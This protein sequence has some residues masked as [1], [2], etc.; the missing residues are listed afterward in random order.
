MPPQDSRSEEPLIPLPF[1]DRQCEEQTNSSRDE[2][3]ENGSGAENEIANLSSMPRNAKLVLAYTWV[4]F[5]G[6][7]LWN[8]N[9]L[10]TLVF[11]L[12]DGDPKAIGFLTAAM[13]MAQ[14]CTSIPTGILADKYRRDTL[15]KVGALVGIAAVASSIRA[16]LQPG[17]RM[18]LV[19]LLLWGI[20]WGIVNT[21][22]TA[23]FSDSIPDGER[24]YYFTK[25]AVLINVA[26]TCGP[27]IALIMF[28]VM[29]DDWTVKECSMVL[30]AGNLISLPGLL[31]LCSMSDNH[32]LN[33]TSDT[34]ESS[35]DLEEPLLPPSRLSSS[36]INTMTTVE[37][38]VDTHRD[39]T[40]DE[41]RLGQRLSWLFCCN[42][43][44]VASLI[45]T[46]DVISGLASGMSIRYIAIFLY[47]NLQLSPVAVQ[48]VYIFN[49]ILQI[50][51]RNKAQL[52]AQT[53]GRCKVTIALKWIGISLMIT[54]VVLYKLGASRILI[55]IVLILRTGFMN[56]P[57]SLTKSV[58]MDHVPKD[59]RAK[60][61][62]LESV[63]MVSWSGSAALGGI[64]V[65]AEGILFN[66][67]FTAFLQFLA[68]GPLVLLSFYDNQSRGAEDSSFEEDDNNYDQIDESVEEDSDEEEQ[69]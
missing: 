5:T 42:K 53:H 22:I 11:L 21:S 45:A 16:S 58:L 54:M 69:N 15:L 17:Y 19:A 12:K 51:L 38:T 50:F 60:W 31:L 23:L 40:Y 30:L 4:A 64:L 68:T 44:V 43:R 61:A 55:C 20:H 46:A 1:F 49:P 67:C 10:A 63:S 52:L 3:A 47:D 37:R 27:V 59:E 62:S 34:I 39:E 66:F 25:R 33:E 28:A 2:A 56:S 32:N 41:E 18:L 57:S 26:N 9:C 13:G 6:R 14:L 8:Q 65:D 7:G 35:N 29:G 24:S 36:T 48:V